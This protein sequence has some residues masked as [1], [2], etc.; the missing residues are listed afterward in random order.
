M[1]DFFSALLMIVLVA[2]SVAMWWR[3]FNATK[4]N[5][6]HCLQPRK[7]PIPPLG[8]L[9]VFAA[10]LFTFSC[11]V[12]ALILAAALTGIYDL[13]FDDMR[14]MTVINFSAGTAQ[15]VGAGITLCYLFLRYGAIEAAGLKPGSIAADLKLGFYGFLLFV[16][17]MLILQGVL[18]IFWE[19]EH[20]TME[21]ISPDSP[22]LAIISAWWTATIVAPFSEEV[23]FRVILLGWLIRCFTYPKDFLGGLIGG[24]GKIENTPTAPI[25][26][27]DDSQSMPVAELVSGVELKRQVTWAPV[28]IVAL[29]FAMVHIGQGPAPIS[30]FFL[31]LGLCYMYQQ[32]GSVVPC[33]LT[34]FLLNTFSMFIFT[35]EQFVFP[36]EESLGEEGLAVPAG[37]VECFASFFQT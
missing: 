31:A 14:H 7:S 6:P 37:I 33:I 22:L 21:M 30:I 4:N 24:I 25:P 36:Q 8:L 17:P 5:Q 27:V 13:D 26:V 23:L 28:F 11:Q 15:L 1:A 12:F 32:T 18:T 16:P 2:S 35:L 3:I 34:H 20:P 9:D 10:I 29:L 19:Y